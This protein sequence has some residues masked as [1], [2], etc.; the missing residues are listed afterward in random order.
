MS[1]EGVYKPKKF[2]SLRS[3]HCFVAYRTLK[4]VAP[5]VIATVSWVGYI[6]VTIAPKI[7]AAQSANLA[8]CLEWMG[9]MVTH[10][11]IFQFRGGI[12]ISRP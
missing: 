9:P 8:T 3:Q 12:F 10:K 7:L 1:Q 11:V 4:T 2:C 6:I 5:R